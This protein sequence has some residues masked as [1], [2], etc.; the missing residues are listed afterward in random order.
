MENKDNIEKEIKDQTEDMEPEENGAEADPAGETPEAG[1]AEEA[2]SAG[3]PGEEETE[4]SAGEGAEGESGA[5]EEAAAEPEAKAEDEDLQHKFMRLSADFQNYRRRT[6]KEKSDIYAY[7]NEKIVS[8]LLEVSDN[9]ERAMAAGCS[10]E[11]F[12][13]GI[14]QILKQLRDVLERSGG[15]EKEAEGADFDPNLHNAVMTLPA[16]NDDQKGKIVQ[17]LQKGYTL[18]GKVIRPAMV[19]VAQE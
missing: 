15:K 12:L 18:N 1:T 13:Q 11:K 2:E 9:F 10:D 8:Q 3:A 4:E 17:V 6:E 5:A 7:A 14:E 19:A 16:E